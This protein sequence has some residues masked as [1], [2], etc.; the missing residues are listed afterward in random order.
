MYCKSLF[1]LSVYYY[2]L[3]TLGGYK[4]NDLIKTDSQLPVE[5][6][7]EAAKAVQEIQAALVVA[8]NFKRRIHDVTIAI[9]SACERRRLAEN[10][11]YA[12]PKGGQMVT[13]PSI[14]LA[15]V[16]AQNWGNLD[17][18]I[19]ELAQENGESTVEAY[20]WD[21]ETNVRQTKVFRVKHERK[22]R[23]KVEKITDPRD[24]YEHVANSGA[25]R[26]RACILGVIP[27]DIVEDA[28]DI[29]N[30]TLSSNS[31]PIGERIKKMAI[32]FK[33][34]GVNTEMLE[35]RLGHKL[36]VVIE[37][38]MVNL[39]KIYVSL[40]DGMSKR[41]DWFK[42]E[43]NKTSEKTEDLNAKFKVEKESK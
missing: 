39:Q 15:E 11:L 3:I 35:E 5:Q 43:S 4:M 20:C 31:E 7:R 12:Y 10:A 25:R 34:I 21:M 24:I 22:A 41:E 2:V 1:D 38:E 27:F 30:K 29:C 28:V 23:G 33:D 8:K 19:R 40:R 14:R 26:L 18:G 9:K 42:F 6:S 32:A 16:L 13:G 37:S 36:D 17:F